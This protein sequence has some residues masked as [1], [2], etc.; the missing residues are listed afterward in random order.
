[1]RRTMSPS[2]GARIVGEEAAGQS[3]LAA[4][5]APFD[6]DAFFGEYWQQC[7]CTVHRD[8]PTHYGALLSLGDVDTLTGML[9]LT[10]TKDPNAA[11]LRAV[12]SEN[13]RLDRKSTRL[14]SS[15]A[16]ISYAVFCLKKKKLVLLRNSQPC[17]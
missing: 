16:N 5:L 11:A 3:A 13:G 12:K 4:L 14:N 15:H 2:A 17:V 9:R 7:P 8:R 6:V 10:P 1:M